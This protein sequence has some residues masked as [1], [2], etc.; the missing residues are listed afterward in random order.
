MSRI[1]GCPD[2]P[3]ALVR[4]DAWQTR[5][6]PLASTIPGWRDTLGRLKHGD[7][8]RLAIDPAWAYGDLGVDAAVEPGEMLVYEL[9]LH[10]F[11]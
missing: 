9:V 10:E 1:E 2:E 5:R 7:F 4:A 6:F 3:S 11:H 8:V